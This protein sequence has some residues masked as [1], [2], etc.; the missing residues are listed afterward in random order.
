MALTATAATATLA[1]FEDNV[2]R[3]AIELRTPEPL[4]G[5]ARLGFVAHL[6][7]AKSLRPAPPVCCH[8]D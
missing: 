6:Y 3:A 1:L 7:V 4:D 8:F 5:G 2:H